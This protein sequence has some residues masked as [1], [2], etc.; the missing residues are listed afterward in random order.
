MAMYLLEDTTPGKNCRDYFEA[1]VD[2]NV[3]NYTTL[4]KKKNKS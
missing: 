2:F 1:W 4:M 3:R